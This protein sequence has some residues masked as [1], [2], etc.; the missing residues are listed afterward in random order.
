MPETENL[1]A[2]LLESDGGEE[3]DESDP[4][5]LAMA[6][7][8][9]LRQPRAKLEVTYL[10][11]LRQ[12]EVALVSANGTTRVV[13]A[14]TLGDCLAVLSSEPDDGEVLDLNDDGTWACPCCRGL[15]VVFDTSS[16]RTTRVSAGGLTGELKACPE[17][18]QQQVEEN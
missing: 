4:A 10:T 17:C 2:E 11:A 12:V 7:E 5:R 6:I 9:E 13:R 14:G 1:L 18:A 16:G 3:D 8:E 15:G